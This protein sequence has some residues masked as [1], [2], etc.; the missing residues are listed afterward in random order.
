LRKNEDHKSKVLN[1]IRSLEFHRKELENLKVRLA[2]R[3]Q[4][5]FDMTVKAIQEKD[6][7]KAGVF[8]NEHTEM[9][10][11]I[12]VVTTSELALTQVMLRMQSITEIG[13][14]MV[15]MNQAFKTMRDVSRTMQDFGPALETASQDISNTLTETMAR[16]GQIA[17]TMSFDIT[18]Q[19]SEDLVEEA[20]RYAEEQAQ[21]MKDDLMLVPA[22]FEETIQDPEKTPVLAT[23]DDDDDD[24]SDGKGFLGVV[25]S[26]PREEKVQAEVL[27]Y[28]VN[29]SGAVDVN[30]ASAT[31]GIPCDEIEHSM[32]KLLAE[33]KVR[34][35]SS[36]E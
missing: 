3:R 10:K 34:L 17:P 28:A 2:E 11:V 19:N 12:K 7:P 13:D 6:R 23:G 24:E 30:R 33:G 9:I 25:Y 4:R 21:K 8:A 20:R 15:H 29:H 35:T 32:L 1:A 36:G 16:M 31:L 26:A 5:L 14:A 18:T 27:K 22:K